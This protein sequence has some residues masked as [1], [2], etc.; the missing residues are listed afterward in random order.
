[1]WL[2]PQVW[3]S[4]DKGAASLLPFWVCFTLEAQVRLSY[5][6]V[7]FPFTSSVFLFW[8]ACLVLYCCGS[9]EENWRVQMSWTEIYSSNQVVKYHLWQLVIV[10]VHSRAPCETKGGSCPFTWVAR[11]DQFIGCLA[12]QAWWRAGGISMDK[13]SASSL[14][15]LAPDFQMV[16]C[17]YNLSSRLVLQSHACLSTTAHWL[18]LLTFLGFTCLV[19]F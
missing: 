3:R 5:F 12:W 2:L 11:K 9:E 1:M 14:F 7:L 18:F 10:T 16:W 19:N 6:P 17:Y 13:A 8:L 15:L 4:L